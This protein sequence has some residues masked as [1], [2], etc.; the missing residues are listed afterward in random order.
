[1][2]CP[3]GKEYLLYSKERARSGYVKRGEGVCLRK[4]QRGK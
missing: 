1:V 3:P 2:S 4:G